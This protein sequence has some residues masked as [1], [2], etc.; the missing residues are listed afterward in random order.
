MPWF[1]ALISGCATQTLCL[2]M[3]SWNGDLLLAL[4]CQHTIRVLANF[5][6]PFW[7]PQQ[8]ARSPSR[9]D[10]EGLQTTWKTN[11]LNNNTQQHLKI[12]RLRDLRFMS[13]QNPQQTPEHTTHRDWGVGSWQV[14]T[15]KTT[16]GDWRVAGWEVATFPTN[17]RA[18]NTWRLRSCRFTWILKSCKLR[19]C[20]LPLE[21]QEHTTHED[22]PNHK[23]RNQMEIEQLKKVHKMLPSNAI[24]RAH[25]KWKWRLRSCRLSSCH[26]DSNINLSKHTWRLRSCRL[27]NITTSHNNHQ[28]K[29]TKLQP[30]ELITLYHHLQQVINGNWGK[31]PTTIPQDQTKQQWRLRS[32]RLTTALPQEQTEHRWNLIAANPTNKPTTKFTLN[33]DFTY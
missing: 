28:N 10:I 6:L 18:S 17:T 7:I 31:L 22:G 3:V 2:A 11:L 4:S 30:Q 23:S 20:N 19:S 8:S 27:T 32:C 26:N 21:T 25:I 9:R 13:C 14:A 15:S 24:T 29:A 12:W 16:N 5:H 33:F 1:L